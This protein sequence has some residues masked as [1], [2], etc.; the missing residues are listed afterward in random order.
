[1]VCTGSAA[2]SGCMA[3]AYTVNCN[4][5]DPK[6]CI[7]MAALLLIMKVSIH[8]AILETGLSLDS[9][10]ELQVLLVLRMLYTDF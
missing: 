7:N 8:F 4:A 5:R 2:T 9:M 10:P 6:E 1:M 3:R